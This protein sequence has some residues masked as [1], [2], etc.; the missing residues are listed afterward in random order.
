MPYKLAAFDFD[1]TLADSLPCF[2]AAWDAAAH[3]YGFRPFD[4]ADVERLRSS[5]MWEAIEYAEIAMW[6]IPMVMQFMRRHMADRAHTVS[7]FPGIEEAIERL[8]A[9]GVELA[10]VTSNGQAMVQRVLGPHAAFVRHLRCD[11]SLFGKRP[12]L[13]QV[14][15]AAGVAAHEAIYVGDEIRDLRAARAEG[16]PFG[17]VEWGFTA[18]ATLR[19]AEPEVM[20]ETVEALVGIGEG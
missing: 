6:Q 5:T 8:A 13:R 17:G 9:R 7:L 18:P 20:F 16:I 19:A 1:G 14:L 10:I 12:K 4:T 11:A 3:R 2:L 15:A